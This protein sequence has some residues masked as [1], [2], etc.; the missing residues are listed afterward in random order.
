MSGAK[1]P[2]LSP[3]E[4]RAQD[5]Q[6]VQSQ[7]IATDVNRQVQNVMDSFGSGRSGSSGRTSFEGHELNAMIDLIE[8]SNRSTSKSRVRHS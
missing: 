8:N 2:E 4:Q 7:L 5:Q 3:K 1:N 6:N